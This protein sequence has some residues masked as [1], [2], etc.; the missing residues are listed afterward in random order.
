MDVIFPQFWKPLVRLYPAAGMCWEVQWQNKESAFLS[1]AICSTW[2]KIP[3][4][5]NTWSL[6]WCRVCY[7]FGIHMGIFFEMNGNL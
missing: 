2:N 6:K 7:V 5:V 3:V 4:F 1:L